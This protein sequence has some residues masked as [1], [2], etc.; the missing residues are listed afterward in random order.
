MQ[1]WY[2]LADHDRELTGYIIQA[3]S[4][5][6]DLKKD[7]GALRTDFNKLLSQQAQPSTA[8][9]VNGDHGFP[10]G[11]PIIKMEDFDVFEEWLQEVDNRNSMVSKAYNSSMVSKWIH[12]Q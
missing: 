11:L 8:Q 10:L 2:L 4:G 6:E 1:N 12:V 5:I 3:I 9:A 7:K